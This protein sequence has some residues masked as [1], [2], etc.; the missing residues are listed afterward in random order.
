MGFFDLFSFGDKILDKFVPG[1]R[2][3]LRAKERKLERQKNSILDRP[4]RLSPR[5]A[6]DLERIAKRLRDIRAKLRDD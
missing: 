1:R 6:R 4:G 5:H 3:R 2:A